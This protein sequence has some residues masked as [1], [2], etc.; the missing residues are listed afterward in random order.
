M[1]LDIYR[2]RKTKRINIRITKADHDW[3]F[4]FAKRRGTKVSKLF[5]TFL[6]FLRAQDKKKEDADTQD[7]V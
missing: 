4:D 7:E 5:A 1:T 6:G 3:L 2:Q